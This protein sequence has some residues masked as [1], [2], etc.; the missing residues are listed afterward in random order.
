MTSS[1]PA[2]PINRP[3]PNPYVGLAPITALITGATGFIGQAVVRDLLDAGHEVI[4]LTRD[5]ARA[6]RQF[7]GRTQAVR[8]LDELADTVKVDVVVNLAGAPVVGPRWS[9][10]RK[11]VLLNSRVG[12]TQHVMAWLARTQHKPRVWVQGSAVG[13]Y[14]VRPAHEVLDETSAPG[15]GF[16]AELCLKWEAA[17]EGAVAMGV[18]QVVLRLGL[19]FGKGGALPM[20]LL[21]YRF[22]LGAR[23]GDGTQMMSWIHHADV[24]GLI[25]QAV[26]DDTMQGMYNA[27]APDTVSQAAFAAQAA[28]AMQRPLWLRLPAAP[29]RLLAG[30]MGQLFLDGQRVIPARLL[31]ARFPFQYPML[32]PVLAA[33]SQRR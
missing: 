10:A 24:L 26:R 21:P 32:T 20:M 19:V 22:A 5:P 23:L 8:D 28:R 1:T 2:R 6:S 14:G 13:A 16:M 27:V 15:V 30:E 31:Q 7:Q 18:R 29:L 25:A 4:V 3:T 9:D 12:T 33:E 17:A 11:Q